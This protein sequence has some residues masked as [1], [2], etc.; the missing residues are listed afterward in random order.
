MGEDLND[1]DFYDK[2]CHYY[3]SCSNLNFVGVSYK[4]ENGG[5]SNTKEILTEL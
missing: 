1:L 3:M 4:A 2:L 5:G